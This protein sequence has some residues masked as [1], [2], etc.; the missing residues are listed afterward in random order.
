MVW[1]GNALLTPNRPTPLCLLLIHAGAPTPEPT[2]AKTAAPVA[3]TPAP[4]TQAEAQVPSV[5]PVSPLTPSPVKPSP[6][7]P[8]PAPTTQ[9]ALESTDRGVDSDDGVLGG[10]HSTWSISVV[11]G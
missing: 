7:A 4:S 9:T 6:V 11:T 5:S 8:S 3:Q 1:S 2:Q 10:E